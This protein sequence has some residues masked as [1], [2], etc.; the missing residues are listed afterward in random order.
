[1]LSDWVSW[2]PEPYGPCLLVPDD[3]G[4]LDPSAWYLW[5]GYRYPQNSGA[6]VCYQGNAHSSWDREEGSADRVGFVSCLSRGFWAKNTPQWALAGFRGAPE[7]HTPAV[8][9]C[10]GQWFSNRGANENLHEAFY[11][12]LFLV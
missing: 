7:S 10:S 6:T 8:F 3:E 12:I 5:V 11:F 1:M 9:R 4:A 2:T